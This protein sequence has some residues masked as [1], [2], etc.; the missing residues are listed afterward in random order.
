[1]MKRGVILALAA[2]LCLS[3][4]CTRYEEV[5]VTAGVKETEETKVIQ[6]TETEPETEGDRELLLIE[7]D[8]KIP[9]YLT[10]EMTDLAIAWRRPVAIMISN[11]K[12]ALPHYGINH[13]GVIYEAPVEPFHG[14]NRGL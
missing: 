12:A 14:C 5:S 13:A 4:G 1:M 10:G 8:G 11:D 2:G 6:I 3:A 7:K 9:S